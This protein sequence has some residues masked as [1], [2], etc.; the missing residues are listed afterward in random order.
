VTEYVVVAGL[1][2]AGRTEVTRNLE[3]LG[4]FIIDNLPPELIPKVAELANARGS[5]FDR[6]ALAV[7]SGR[8]DDEILPAINSLRTSAS[9]VRIVFLEASTETLVRRYESSR[10]RHPFAPDAG[11]GISES[12]DRERRALEPLRAAADVV[13]DTSDLN[14]NELRGRIVELFAERSPAALMSM[15]ITSFGYKY[16]LPLDVDMVFDCRFLPN[17]H[18]VD[19]LRPKSGL[20][21]PVLEYVMAQEATSEFLRELERMLELLV[22]LY[23]QEGKA[24]LSVAFGCTG[25]RHRSVVIAEQAARIL[26]RLGLE[27]A[28]THRDIDR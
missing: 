20:D 11:I 28:I 13:I 9:R 22:P 27:P 21:T 18:W 7:G 5:N 2:G 10:R 19:E 25:G 26:R 17:P 12:I 16:G 14:V 6:V 24:Y 4:W 3:D 8:N 1:S 15:R 23:V